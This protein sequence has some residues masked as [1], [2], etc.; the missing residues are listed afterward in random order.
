MP[1]NALKA[2]LTDSS[3]A[4]YPATSGQSSTK[5]VPA[6]NRLASLPRTAPFNFDKSYS[7]RSSS[8]SSLLRFFFLLLPFTPCR[9]ARANDSGAF[10]P[11][12]VRHDQKSSRVGHPDCNEAAFRCGMIWVIRGDREGISKNC[13]LLLKP[14][15]VLAEV[16]RSFLRIPFKLHPNILKVPMQAANVNLCLS[17][18]WQLP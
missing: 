2:A 7:G 4:K 1:I 16:E 5:L 3:S 9:L 14:N 11:V 15:T 13:R 8:C 18:K 6:L 12:G 10:A 17:L